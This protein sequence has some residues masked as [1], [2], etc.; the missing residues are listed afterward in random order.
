MAF[1]RFADKS[2][3]VL[4]SVPEEY[5]QKRNVR[6][7]HGVQRNVLH[8]KSTGSDSDKLCQVSIIIIRVSPFSPA[9]SIQPV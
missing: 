5:E 6:F 2:Q 1:N 9:R 3:S 8:R 4:R 7:G